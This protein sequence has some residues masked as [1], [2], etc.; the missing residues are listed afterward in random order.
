MELN[1]LFTWEKKNPS[2]FQEIKKI[3]KNR[4][5]VSILFS[6]IVVALLWL[7]IKNVRSSA[8]AKNKQKKFKTHK[9]CGNVH[10]QPTS[11]E[12]MNLKRPE[13]V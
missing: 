13:V 4:V 12:L 3:Q 1:L 11:G 9:P 5:T 10:L 6:Y 8:E 7:C 2:K